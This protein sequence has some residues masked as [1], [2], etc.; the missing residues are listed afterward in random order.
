MTL[1]ELQKEIKVKEQEL[2]ALQKKLQFYPNVVLMGRVNKGKYS[3]VFQP[4][5]QVDNL[6]RNGWQLC[7]TQDILDTEKRLNNNF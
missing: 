2:L 3:F 5:K 7:T 4:V 1:E 6:K